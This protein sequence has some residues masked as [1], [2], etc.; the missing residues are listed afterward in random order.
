[1][2]NVHQPK[3]SPLFA[4]AP[5]APMVGT[6]PE[7]SFWPEH[8]VSNNSYCRLETYESKGGITVH[9]CTQHLGRACYCPPGY[10]VVIDPQKLQELRM[11]SPLIICLW[12]QFYTISLRIDKKKIKLWYGT[13]NSS[14]QKIG[15]SFYEGI[16]QRVKSNPKWI[17]TFYPCTCYCYQPLCLQIRWNRCLHKLQGTHLFNVHCTLYRQK[18]TIA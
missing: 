8:N 14:I 3:L 13:A 15:H 5:R 4:L 11:L 17:P 12:Q 18:K 1:M 9:R 10:W 6:I 2:A 7:H 16:P